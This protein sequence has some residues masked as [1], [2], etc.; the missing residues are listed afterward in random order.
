MGRGK[1]VTL[2]VVHIMRFP[3]IL[4]NIL[5]SKFS[6]TNTVFVEEWKINEKGKYLEENRPTSI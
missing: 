6:K 1:K 2:K 5:E 4:P 3:R